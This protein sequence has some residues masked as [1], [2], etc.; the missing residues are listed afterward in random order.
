VGCHAKKA[1]RMQNAWKSLNSLAR[2]NQ[3]VPDFA[4]K[5]R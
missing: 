2:L 3:L 5:R 1:E 4:R